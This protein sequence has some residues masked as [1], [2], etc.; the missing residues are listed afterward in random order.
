MVINKW[1]KITFWLG[2]GG[3]IETREQ[4]TIIFIGMPFLE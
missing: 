2:G 4:L 3:E 1:S